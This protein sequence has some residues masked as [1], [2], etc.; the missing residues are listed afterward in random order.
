MEEKTLKN[1]ILKQNKN[2]DVRNF[3]DWLSKF[4]FC[5]D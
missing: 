1:L 2:T 4:D 3:R 5:K